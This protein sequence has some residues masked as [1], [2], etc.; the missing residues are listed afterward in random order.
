[1]VIEVG[2]GP[3]GLTRSLLNAR[4]GHVV[5]IEKDSRFLPTLQIL[6]EAVGDQMT[7]VIEDMMK[8]ESC[9]SL[10]SL[11]HF[12]GPIHIVGNLP[13]NIATPLLIG[14][15]RDCQNRTGIFQFGR[16]CMTLMFQK[17]VT[18]VF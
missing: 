9:S 10:S 17:E 11:S 18:K 8:W 16:V 7:V 5:V 6:K 12:P 14:W 2:P 3:G 15:L 13:F 4:A 1:M